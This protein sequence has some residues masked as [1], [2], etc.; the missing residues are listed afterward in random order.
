MEN[1]L[2]EGEIKEVI[3]TE[4]DGGIVSAEIIREEAEVTKVSDETV[5]EELKTNEDGSL[6]EV[7]VYRDK[8]TGRIVTPPS[9]R[10]KNQDNK[11]RELCWEYYMKTVRDGNPN[12]KQSALKAGFSENTALNIGNIK[13]FKDKKDK[14]RRS[15]MMTNAE[16]NIARMLNIGITRLKKLEDGT[17]EEVFD[18]EKAR[19][20][21]DMSKLIVTTL[22]KD[23][24]WS[25]KTEVKVTAMPTPILQLDNVIE[26]ELIGNNEVTE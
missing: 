10:N 11:R 13:W 26:N 8:R 25:T 16:R 17:T 18:A 1:N 22:G 4:D 24:G 9:I 19:I 23:E 6:E 5:T 20:V 3:F 14:L 2:E 12:G 15:K 7:E 21:A